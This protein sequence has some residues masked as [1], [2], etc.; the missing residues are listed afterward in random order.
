M[1]AV[2]GTTI[3]TEFRS[4]CDRATKGEVFLV[5]RPKDENIVIISEK[6][7]RR[8]MRFKAYTDHLAAVSV[9]GEEAPNAEDTYPNGFFD[10]FGAGKSLGL[11]ERPAELL[12][13]DDGKR[14]SV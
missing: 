7:Y 2:K 8:L 11:D 10:L 6:E 5:T 4:I 12:W 14:A 9:A 1:V 13:A 3:K